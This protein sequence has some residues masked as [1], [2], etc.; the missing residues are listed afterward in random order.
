MAK[1]VFSAQSNIIFD[2]NNPLAIDAFYE[3]FIEELKKYGNEVLLIRT[4]DI[5]GKNLSKNNNTKFI[6]SLALLQKIKK[7]KPDL[8]I[9]ANHSVPQVILDSTSCPVAVLNSDS[10][11]YYNCKE[12]I[13]KNIER[14]SFFHFDKSMFFADNICKICGAKPEQNYFLGNATSVRSKTENIQDNIVFLGIF[15]WPD[16]IQYKVESVFSQAGLEQII[17]EYEEALSCK[18]KYSKDYFQTATINKRIKILEALSDLGLKIHCYQR[19]AAYLV[20]Y[21]MN[22]LKCCDITPVYSVKDIEKKYNSSL[23]APTLPNAQAITG[24]SWRVTEVMASNA[25]LISN[26]SKDLMEQFPFIPIYNS[27]A[28]ARELCKKLLS[29]KS[30]RNDIVEQSHE[31]IEQ[32]YRFI[33]LFKRLENATGINITADK[34]KKIGTIDNSLNER[35]SLGCTELQKSKKRGLFLTILRGIL[36]IFPYFL[37]WK[38]LRKF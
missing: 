37:V 8:I 34:E 26:P 7:F 33:H 1:I 14:Y 6:I 27:P 35:F 30:W 36:K 2:I 21:S 32:N 25:C 23:I 22:L 20:P 31:T 15:G 10:V 24:F 5:L 12:Y 4:N 17:K 16:N 13:K 38:I 29:D 18:D 11:V 9:T 3:G 28:E 19:Q